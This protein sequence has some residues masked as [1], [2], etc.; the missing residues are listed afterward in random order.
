MSEDHEEALSEVRREVLTLAFVSSAFNEAE[1]L[2]EL[3]RRC[4]AA[5]AELQREFAERV[6]LDFRFVIADN[7]SKDDSLAVLEEL[8][9]RDPG[10]LAL[11]NSMNYGV[12]ASFGNLIHLACAYDLVVILCSDLQDPPEMAISMVGTLLERP[13]LDSVLAVK[14]RSSGGLLLQFAR[15]T[16]YRVLGLSSRRSMV[17]SG[18][19]GFGCY[20]QVVLEEAT[21]FWKGTDL[22]LRQCLANACQS[23]LLTRYVQLDRLR[24]Q[25]SYRGWGYWI[26]ALR[27]LLAGDAAASRLAL[28]IGGTGLVLALLLGLLLSFNFLRGNSGYGGGVP[29]VMGLVLVS[30]A[31][32]M[33]MF[34]V[35]S[36][37]IEGLRMGGFRQTVVFRQ[38]RN[39]H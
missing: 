7:G 1:N 28:A 8:S 30:F 37:Q 29:T 17:P 3:H 23:P 36:R 33:L 14:E 5:H 20:R 38:L 34:A 9:G 6:V 18:F 24:G 11:A 31:L 25:S 21:R 13:E 19:H 10:V 16:Y 35:L 22:N 26:E 39:E 27:A 15:R 4:R 12:E 32:Q 2:E